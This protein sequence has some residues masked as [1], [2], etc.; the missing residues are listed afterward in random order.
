MQVKNQLYKFALLLILTTPILSAETVDEVAKKA[1]LAS[2]NTLLI[3]TSQDSLN[4]GLYHFTKVGVDMHVYHLPFSYTLNP[5]DDSIEYFLVGNVGYSTVH[6][7]KD[8][9]IPLEW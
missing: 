9:N 2:I 8:I 4:S 6:L 7:S 5:N 1:H 3:F